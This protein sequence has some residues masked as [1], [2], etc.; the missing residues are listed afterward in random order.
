MVADGIVGSG[1]RGM[2]GGGE[3]REAAEALFRRFEVNELVRSCE[4]S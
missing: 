4:P 1:G 2:A 3:G